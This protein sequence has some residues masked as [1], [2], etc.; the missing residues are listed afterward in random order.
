MSFHASKAETS[1]SLLLSLCGGE[2]LQEAFHAAMVSGQSP[3]LLAH[4]LTSPPGQRVL[5]IV[6]T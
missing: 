3:F 4:Q 6:I 5:C 2:L 1:S